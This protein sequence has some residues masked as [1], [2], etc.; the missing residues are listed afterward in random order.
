MASSLCS[1]RRIQLE[2]RTLSNQIKKRESCFARLRGNSTPKYLTTIGVPKIDLCSSL[3]TKTILER[4]KEIFFGS[5]S[6]GASQAFGVLWRRRSCSSIDLL[7]SHDLSI[8]FGAV[9]QAYIPNAIK[10]FFYQVLTGYFTV[11]SYHAGE[12]E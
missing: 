7:L 6:T 8:K 5:V 10:N 11:C 3:P 12:P 4:L 2:Q 9:T 1:S